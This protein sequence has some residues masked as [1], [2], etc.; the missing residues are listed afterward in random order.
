MFQLPVFFVPRFESFRRRILHMTGRDVPRITPWTAAAVLQFRTERARKPPPDTPASVLPA[1]IGTLAQLR[2]DSSF[3]RI[4]CFVQADLECFTIRWSHKHFICLQ[5]VVDV[6]H[7]K[8]SRMM[9]TIGGTDSGNIRRG[10]AV[11]WLSKTQRN[12]N[13]SIRSKRASDRSI[14]KSSAMSSISNSSVALASAN[15]QQIDILYTGRGGIRKTLELYVP[16]GRGARLTEALQALLKMDARI[17]WPSHWYWTMSCMAAT[18]QRGATGFL[19][20]AELRSLL[21]RANAS[22][23]IGTKEVKAA[24]IKSAGGDRLLPQWMRLAAAHSKG[25]KHLGLRQVVGLLVEMSTRSP[26]IE[27][28][29]ERY[30]APLSP[31]QHILLAEDDVEK[32]MGV[33]EWLEFVDAEQFGNG[34][35]LC[36]TASSFNPVGSSHLLGRSDF[37]QDGVGMSKEEEAKALQNFEDAIERGS[38]ELH[39]PDGLNLQQFAL[40]LLSPKN[41]AVL[42]CRSSSDADDLHRGLWHFWTACSHNSYIVGDQL[43]GLSSAAMY[44]RQL[45]QGCRHVEVNSRTHTSLVFVNSR[46]HTTVQ[47]STD[48]TICPNAAD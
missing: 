17:A 2:M 48:Y 12:L 16:S 15:L 1:A 42:P 26:Q 4:T 3:P 25:G 36:K 44:R 22:V 8:L 45:I 14:R 19:R 5:T 40:Q 18:S 46:T 9:S 35:S 32:R 21:R 7:R 34:L 28:L 23:R 38:S 29:F 20:Q 37:R 39:K 30:A 33:A 13:A 41:D 47:K 27:Q 10:L 24:L 43:T 11:M 6:H 31:P